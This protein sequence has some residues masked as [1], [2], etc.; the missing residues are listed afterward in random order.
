MMNELILHDITKKQ[1]DNFIT[2]PTHALLL[3][4][5]AGVGKTAIAEALAA[6]IV[7]QPISTH[8][9]FLLIKP[10]NSSISIDS[11]RALQKFL[12][13]KTIGDRPI[14]RIV[15]VEQAQTLT[16]EAQN[17]FLKLLEEPPADTLVII[18][19][20][21]PRALLPTILSRV[22]TIAVHPPTEEQL[23]QM[24]SGTDEE[25][26]SFTQAYLLSGGLPGLMHALLRQDQEHSLIRS[27]NLAKDILRMPFFERLA[28]TDALS[29]QK[30]VS[31]ELVGALERIAQAGLN[32]AG[33]KNDA[34]SLHR[35]HKIRKTCLKA[36]QALENSASIKLVLDNLFLRI[37]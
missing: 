35:W 19:A 9:Y 30:D 10:E 28:L 33:S 29:K 11:I 24:A 6:T 21:R 8:P 15:L 17:A 34:I 31:L 4:G 2:N 18:A 14:R 5:P 12:L 23:K 25:H 37:S 36:Q 20:E 1:L 22:Q 3:A 26:S 27:V 13:L 16:K 7:G 32:A